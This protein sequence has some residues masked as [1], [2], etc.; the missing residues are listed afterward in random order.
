MTAEEKY[1]LLNCDNLTQPIQMELSKKQKTFSDL[2][3]QFF[4]SRWNFEIFKL[5]DDPHG[6]CFSEITGCKRRGYANV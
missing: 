4:K 5:K 1:S 2:F 6:L 3:S